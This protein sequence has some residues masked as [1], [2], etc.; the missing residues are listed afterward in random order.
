MNEL[1]SNNNIVY[2]CYYH[3]VFCPKYRRKVLTQPIANRLRTIILEVVAQ[4]QAECVKMEIMPDHVHL[5]LNCDPQ[6]GI[7]RLVKYIKGT[8][9]YQLRKEFPELTHRLPS[10]WTNSYCV[11]TTG[12]TPIEVIKRYIENQKG[13]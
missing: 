6:F 2:S 9:S 11:L 12:G 1:K 8:S 10:L 3:V 4:W 7:H 5:L 13:K